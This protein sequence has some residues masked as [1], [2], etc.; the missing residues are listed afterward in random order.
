MHVQSYP[1]PCIHLFT[2]KCELD[3]L[4]KLVSLFLQEESEWASPTFIIPKNDGCDCWLMTFTSYTRWLV[5]MILYLWI[6]WGEPKSLHH[7]NPFRKVQAH[8]LAY[9]LE[10]FSWHHSSSNGK[11]PVRHWC[12]WC[13]YWSRRML[14][15][16][17]IASC[18]APWHSSLAS[19]WQQVHHWFTQMW[20]GCPRNRPSW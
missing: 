19:Q 14:L 5:S 17:M 4:I 12:S 15:L 8:L 9:G 11:C 20:M 13:V 3:H 10:M 16:I 6:C 2:I 1:L 7:H 18:Q